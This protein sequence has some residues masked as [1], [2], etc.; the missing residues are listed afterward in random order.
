MITDD[1]NDPQLHVER[2]DGQNEKYLVLSQ[3]ERD[4]GFVRPVRRSYIH[5][6]CG[7][8]TCMGLELCETYARDP[9]FY[10]GTF[11]VGCR[12]HFPVAEFKWDE[13]GH[14]VG[15]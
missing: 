3:E 2:P 13:D 9:K 4:K 6:R 14:V 11:C 10:S 8:L 12:A 15:S 7:A 1:R 5:D